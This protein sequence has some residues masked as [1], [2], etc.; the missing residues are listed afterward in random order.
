M[1]FYAAISD[2]PWT[3]CT[4]HGTFRIC[5]EYDNMWWY[6]RLTETVGRF[7]MFAISRT[8]QRDESVFR[9]PEIWSYGYKQDDENHA[10]QLYILIVKELLADRQLSRRALC[11]E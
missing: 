4:A 7:N 9:S 1:Y 8:C 5:S 3:S 11:V 6:Q 2:S 10:L